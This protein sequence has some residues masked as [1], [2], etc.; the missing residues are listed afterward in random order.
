MAT[1]VGRWNSGMSSA[2]RVFSLTCNDQC[3]CVFRPSVDVMQMAAELASGPGHL[4]GA[5][6]DGWRAGDRSWCE[7]AAEST[8]PMLV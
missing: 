4:Q 5:L 6:L 7:H 3:A 8:C 2:P 1:A